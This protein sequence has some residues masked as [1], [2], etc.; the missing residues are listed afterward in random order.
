M[1]YE[2]GWHD[3]RVVFVFFLQKHKNQNWLLNNHQR[4]TK[5]DILHSLKDK[6]VATRW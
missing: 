6:E 4:S 1:S 3:G 2:I 5:K